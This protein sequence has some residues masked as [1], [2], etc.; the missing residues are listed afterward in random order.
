MLRSYIKTSGRSIAR[1][2][3][4]SF[5]NIVGLAISMSVGLLMIAFLSDLLSYDR[6]HERGSRIYRV[7]TRQETGGDQARL[8]STSV[9]AGKKIRES[10]TGVENLVIIRNGFGGDA[11]YSETVV[12]ITGLWA[13]EQFFDVFSF[14]FLEGDQRTALKEPYSIVLTAKSAKKVFGDEDALGKTIKFDSLSY[15]V[16]G[17]LKEVPKF[18]HIQFEALASFSTVELM[19]KGGEAFLA[20]ESVESNYVYLVLSEGTDFGRLQKNLDALSAREN[21]AIRRSRI[22]LW[23]Q[24][25]Y[26]IA[27]GP[28]LANQIG[29]AISLKIVWLVA[30]L[31]FIVL[32]SA[33]FN[34]ANLSI[35]RSLR[36]SREV[37]IRKVIGALTSHV[38]GQFVVEAVL[39]ALL[40]L[41]FSFAVFLFLRPLFLSITPDL[42]GMVSLQLS[43]SVIA[44][45]IVFAVTVGIAAGFLPALFFSRINPVNVLK[46]ASSV[47]VFKNVT[48]RKALIV[49]QYTFSLMF[50]TA[51]M[52]GYTQYK[53]LLTFDLGFNTAKILNISLQGNKPELLKKEFTEIPEVERVAISS[54]VPGVNVYI[55]GNMRYKEDSAWI[56]A[57]YVDEN[58]LP[59]HD[60]RLLAGRNFTAKSNGTSTEVIVSEATL[61]RFQIGQG[62]PFMAIGEIVTVNGKE[63]EIIGVMQDF[64]YAKA[65]DE[66]KPVMFLYSRNPRP[67]DGYISAKIISSDWPATRMK[68]EK[69]WKKIDPVHPFD[70]TFYEVQ[71]EQAYGQYF[72]MLKII[73]FLAFLAISISSLGLLGM[74]VFTTETRLKE[75]SIRKVLGATDGSLIFLLGRGFILLLILSAM[76]AL[77]ATYLFFE[78]VVLSNIAYRAPIGVLEMFSRLLIVTAIAIVMIGGQTLKVT[79]S[80]PAKVLKSE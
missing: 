42:P 72:A 48:M 22:S 36:R 17:I 75:V 49:V 79:R 23:L 80:N 7:S 15:V 55:L 10:M 46:D 59:L 16:T 77:P 47:R 28:V 60:Y 34:Y 65:T 68:L 6:F 29:P 74:V 39:V 73:G 67:P 56:P 70:A 25:L 24:P 57:N 1:N 4:F 44:Y 54:M 3:L 26:G 21:K 8:A 30:G 14:Q 53:H 51:T 38:L 66:V 50:I 71:L 40:A 27:L 43:P 20:W 11:R 52:I 45:F 37:G 31:A 9:K 18:S 5:I 19:K 32:L 13:E 62:I 41:V 78:R 63:K 64:H 2:K 69:V 61:K 58:Y 76:V 35:A 12:P 33:C